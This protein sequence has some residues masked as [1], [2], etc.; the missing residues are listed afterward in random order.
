[1]IHGQG[2]VDTLKGIGSYVYENKDLI[3][4]PMLGAVG[5]IGAF[6]MAEAS[7]ALIRKIA[8]EKQKE[9]LDPESRQIIEN[10]KTGS[11]IK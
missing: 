1:M 7:K 5:D 4:K 3:A 10:L 8:A 2:F 11:G 9:Q 6:A